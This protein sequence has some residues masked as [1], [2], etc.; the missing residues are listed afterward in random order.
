[1]PIKAILFD[2]D[3]TLFD[4]EKTWN[5]WSLSV[6]HHFSEGDAS[7]ASRIADAIGFDL[8]EECFHPD[9]PVIA[10]TNREAAE[11]ISSSLGDPDVDQVEAYLAESALNAPLAPAVPLVPLMQRFRAKGLKLGVVTNDTQQG[12]QHHLRAAEALELF[13]FV[14][15]HDSGVGAKP[16]PDPLLAFA[17]QVQINPKDIAMVGDSTHDL[18]AGRRAGMKT[19]GVLT[20]MAAECV[21]S[22][23]SDVVLPDIGHLPAWL[24]SA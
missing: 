13:D 17:Q 8:K 2:K 24:E 9:S 12:A 6:I 22:P 18:I 11:L 4:F 1:M 7:V 21:L 10:G 23:Y 5:A 16:D 20:G 19:V 14:V 15:G 3:G